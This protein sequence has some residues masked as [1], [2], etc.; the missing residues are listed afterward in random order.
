M[1]SEPLA[2]RPG[3]QARIDTSVSTT[4]DHPFEIG[5]AERDGN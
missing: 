3:E 2:Q 5:A 4:L 1:L